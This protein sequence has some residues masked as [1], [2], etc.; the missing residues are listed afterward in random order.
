MILQQFTAGI[1]RGFRG[2]ISYRFQLPE[3]LQS[4]QLRLHYNKEHIQQ[5]E[6]YLRRF[7]AELSPQLAAYLGHEPTEEELSRAVASMK[8]EIQLCLMIG[9]R[10]VGNVHMPGTDKEMFISAEEASRGCLPCGQ[11]SGMAEIIVN[12]L[13]VM[14]DDVQWQL[15]I[16]G[17]FGKV[18]EPARCL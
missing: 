14:E 3:Q 4:L 5:Q 10:F 15:E 2:N 9:G 8:T 6:R 16:L 12:V 18:S 13:G 7:Q 1:S 17:E 11:L